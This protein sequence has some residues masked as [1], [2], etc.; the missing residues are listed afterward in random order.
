MEMQV[1][2]GQD[3]LYFKLS[4]GLSLKQLV[5]ANPSFL[6]NEDEAKCD[7]VVP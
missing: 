6:A 7:F 4:Q 5:Q 2:N 1:V 3:R